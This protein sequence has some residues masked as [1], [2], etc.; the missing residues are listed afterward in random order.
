MFHDFCDRQM[1]RELIPSDLIKIQSAA[2]W[3]RGIVAAYIQDAGNFFF[4]E[5]L[6]IILT[7]KYFLFD[8][9]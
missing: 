1:I 3:K 6:I 2:E 7:F 5:Q 8:F 4:F 9:F